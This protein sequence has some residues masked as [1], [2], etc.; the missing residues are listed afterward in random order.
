MTIIVMFSYARSGGTILNQCLGSLP[1]VVIMSEV[2]PLGGGWGVREADSLTT[3]KAQA[4]EWYKIDLKNDDF[5]KNAL[6]L[7]QI[8]QNQHQF[9]IL[10]DWTFVNFTSY[11]NNF[12]V[13]PR[14]F[15]TLDALKNKAE[16]K[17]FALVRDAIDVW[18]SRGC[19]PMN[20][21]YADYLIYI[22]TLLQ[23]GIKIFKYENFCA[24]PDRTMFEICNYVNIPYSDD[25]KNYSTFFKVNGDVQ[26]KD[27][28]RGVQQGIIKPLRRKKLEHEKVQMLNQNK[29]MIQ[30][31]QLLGYPTYY[32]DDWYKH[33]V[34]ELKAKLKSFTF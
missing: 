4:K 14:R 19:P 28:S 21:F 25:Y 18:L 23:E 12:N 6:E 5:T 34:F 1:N 16:V 2:N 26:N 15:L 33:L 31:N 17:P 30:V 10:R 32:K 11:E 29:H 7:D 24:A 13:P 27:N 8:C 9:L 3:I 20:E 22:Q